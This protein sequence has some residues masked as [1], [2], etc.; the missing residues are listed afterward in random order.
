MAA[1]M[2][3]V[4]LGAVPVLPVLLSAVP[5]GV[6]LAAV[7]LRCLR[8]PDPL[9]GALAGVVGPPLILLAVG[10]GEP[11]RVARGAVAAGLAGATYLIVAMLPGQG[12]GF[13]DVKLAAV[14]AFPL[15]YLGW[16]A[17]AAGL[18]APHLLNGP[19]AVF[20]LVTGRARRGTALPLGPAL[21]AGALLGAVV[22]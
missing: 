15:G 17:V 9:V 11:G 3:A 18:V 4:A 10:G 12:L 8:L 21:L 2:L 5:L 14:L 20:L 16:P 7:D 19:V 1:A 22:A 6:L 13:G